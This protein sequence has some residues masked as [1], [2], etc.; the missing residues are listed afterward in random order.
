MDN[1]SATS[2]AVLPPGVANGGLHLNPELR[3]IL[4]N[5][6]VIVA[7]VAITEA[8]SLSGTGRTPAALAAVGY[9]VYAGWLCWVETRGN[10]PVLPR[11]TPWVDAGWILL[12]AWLA[13]AQS[14]LFILLLLFPVLFA[15]LSF[16]FVSGLLVSLFAA[17]VAA[18]QLLIHK[19]YGDIPWQGA[20][21]QPLSLLVLGPLVA[22]LARAGVQ[23]NEQLTVADRLLG[24]LDPRRGV[25]RIA[26]TT[27]RTL[28]HHFD[29]DRGLILLWLPDSEPR[30]FD[31][32]ASGNVNELSGELHASLV[33]S[34][35]C[36]PPDVAAVHHL[37][38]VGRLPLRRHSGFD[39]ETR[40]SNSAARAAAEQ[41]AQL[42]DAQ[43]MVAM[44]ICRRAPHP[45]RLLLASRHRRYRARDAELLYGVMEQLAPVIENAG[46]LERLTEAAMATERARIGR[47]LHDTAIQPYLGL[48]YGIEA[49]ARKAAPDN[50]LH[51]DIHALKDV[52]I[53]ELHHLRE[54]VTD[55]RA[56]ACG[57]DDAL[58]PALRRQAKRFSEL[59]GIEVS[60][61]CEGELPVR[62]SLAAAIFAMVGEAL[63]NIRRH[64][65]ASRAEIVVSAQ[66]GVCSLRI[67]NAHDPHAP[68]PPFIPRSIVER[69]ESLHGR[70]VV[71][72]QRPGLTDLIIS[73]PAHSKHGQP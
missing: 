21:L 2:P 38:H 67:T 3:R 12:F 23:M 52:A 4:A 53:S 28:T 69:A 5:I 9:A 24:Q 65:D 59:F 72:R 19:G 27:L 35:G 36:L 46:L 44:P 71:E 40:A 20:M 48:K 49:L 51:R 54:L 70:A 55:M 68:P 47:D 64:T 50:P 29:A 33:E 6:R 63:T 56:G 25:R 26:E 11:I 18:A 57:A 42:L 62:R 66:A 43:S 30:L 41:L 17:A 45:C 34:L 13:E 14:S 61:C 73:I 16:G 60:V 8:L 39:L 22:A 32:D 31:C 10:H 7:I 37:G 58:A 1:S 15:S